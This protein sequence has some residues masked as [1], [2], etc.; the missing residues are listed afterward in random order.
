MMREMLDERARR[1]RIDQER[2]LFLLIQGRPP[3]RPRSG[4]A[5]A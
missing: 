1:R 3:G 4:F 2:R 5:L